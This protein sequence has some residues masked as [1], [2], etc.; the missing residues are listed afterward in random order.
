MVCKMELLKEVSELK[1][2]KEGDNQPDT[3]AYLWT[4]RKLMLVTCTP[5]LTEAFTD[6]M[7]IINSKG[8]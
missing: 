2:F 8:W 1:V 4:M 7:Y 5:T 3:K 6:G